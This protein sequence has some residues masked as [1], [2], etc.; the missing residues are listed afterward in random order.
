MKTKY[1]IF[2][3]LIVFLSTNQSKSQSFTKHYTWASEKHMDPG[4]DDRR[5]PF[6]YSDIMHIVK[7]DFNG[8]SIPELGLIINKNGVFNLFTIESRGY[9]ILDPIN[10]RILWIN[11]K[12][13]AHFT[14]Q[15]L[16]GGI[17]PIYMLTSNFDGLGKIIEDS[18]N[19]VIDLGDMTIEE[20]FDNIRLE[21]YPNPAD[22]IINT[23]ARYPG[24]Y[25]IEHHDSYNKILIQLFN[26]IGDK[27]F[28]IEVNPGE[29]I[30]IPT[31]KFSNGLYFIR[32][33]EN[34][35]IWSLELPLSTVENVIIKK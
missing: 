18:Y 24:S 31:D 6:K 19:G 4:E 1:L 30:Q 7:G 17:P 8:D 32:A 25:M 27:L 5:L 16:L 34:T 21:I 20:E 12:K 13:D 28:D 26:S 35:D 9:R 3:V 11:K 22:N 15:L 10:Y 14:Q 2:L 33:E 29:L 23:I